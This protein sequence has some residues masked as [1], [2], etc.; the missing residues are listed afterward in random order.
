MIEFSIDYGQWP[1]IITFYLRGAP[2]QPLELVP[3]AQKIK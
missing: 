3:L 2:G 1:P